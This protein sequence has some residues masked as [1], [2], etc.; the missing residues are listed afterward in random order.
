MSEIK[1]KENASIE[2]HQESNIMYLL[3]TPQEQ[4]D[5]QR[6]RQYRIDYL[7]GQIDT[8][9]Q[10]RQHLLEWQAERKQGIEE[11]ESLYR[12]SEQMCEEAREQLRVRQNTKDRFWRRLHELISEHESLIEEEDA[13]FALIRKGI[14][15]NQAEISELESL[16][17]Q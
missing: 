2:E 9:E 17:R 15:Q 5:A 10:L 1:P 8:K 4:T 11:Q 16:D 14:E 7:R 3:P 6:N 13:H 12:Q